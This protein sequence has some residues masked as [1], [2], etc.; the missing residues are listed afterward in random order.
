MPKEPLKTQSLRLPSS[1]W[2]EIEAYRERVGAVTLA[3]AVRRLLLAG[4]RA[5]RRKAEK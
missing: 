2:A 4:L 3:D 5:E 1:V